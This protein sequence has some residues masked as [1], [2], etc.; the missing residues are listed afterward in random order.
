MPMHDRRPAHPR[1]QRAAA[2][3][4]SPHGLWIAIGVLTFLLLFTLA[5]AL[6]PAHG[7]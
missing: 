1:R 2:F 7:R 3:L 4:A 6:R 5:Q